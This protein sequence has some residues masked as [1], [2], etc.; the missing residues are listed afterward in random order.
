MK[1][2]K[3]WLKCT[4]AILL[5]T[6]FIFAKTETSLASARY[7]AIAYSETTGGYAFSSAHPNKDNAIM[8]AKK[9]LFS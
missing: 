3:L 7:G 2:R 8:D 4:L 6:S 9:N 1:N 5:G